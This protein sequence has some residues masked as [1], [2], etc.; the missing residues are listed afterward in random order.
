M[1][2]VSFRGV[3]T[4]LEKNFVKIK[5][6]TSSLQKAPPRNLFRVSFSPAKM[7]RGKHL[8]ESCLGG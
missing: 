6:E 5:G 2:Y 1:G 7:D 3:H 8:S 4:T